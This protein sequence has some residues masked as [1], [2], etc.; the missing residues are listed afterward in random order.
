MAG[1]GAIYALGAIGYHWIGMI[2]CHKT[3]HV[4]T[5]SY[6]TA[7]GILGCIHCT[8]ASSAVA[9]DGAGMSNPGPVF[10]GYSNPGTLGFRDAG[11]FSDEGLVGMLPDLDIRCASSLFYDSNISQAPADGLYPEETDFILS[12]SPSIEWNK[13]NSVW[14]FGLGCSASY[15][16][17]LDHSDF[18]GL[19]Y[20]FSGNA[21]YN[22]GNLDLATSFR[23][24]FNQ[25]ANRYYGASVATQSYGFSTTASYV[26]SRKTSLVASW[27]SSW[28]S[29]DEGFG[30]TENHSLGLSAMWRYSPLLQFGPGLRLARASGDYQNDRDSWGPTISVNYRLTRKVSLNG[31]LGLD[32]VNYDGESDNGCSGNIGAVYNLN[33]F[34]GFDLAFNKDV[35]ADGSLPGLFRDTTGVRI[36]VNR[37]IRHATARLGLGY[38][39]A[40]YTGGSGSVLPS[41]LD[42]ATV[43]CSLS[44]PV[45]K[46]AASATVFLRY[47]DNASDD[48]NRDWNG[49]QLGCSIGYQF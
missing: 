49:F 24:S 15:N 3:Q 14:N 11:N 36:G 19:D 17:Y 21:G 13:R 33:R 23:Q 40:A 2:D 5:K 25:G 12:V 43:D 30:A 28:S 41:A 18:S 27:N 9:A 42:Y 6:F 45:F 46:D 22:A 1:N 37:K 16:E 38:E 34:W 48:L 8:M 35:T 10:S 31:S 44:M 7:A 32:V 39:H 26:V 20:G 29:P 4:I 47:Q